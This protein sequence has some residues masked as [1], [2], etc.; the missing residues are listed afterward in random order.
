MERIFCI[1]G[2]A[3]TVFVE[4]SEL[5]D[6]SKIVRKL[7]NHGAKMCTRI[8]D[9]RFIIVD[10]ETFSG[11]LIVSEWGQVPDKIILAHS[12][13]SK[14]VDAKRLLDEMD[15]WGGCAAKG[16]T[17]TV[18]ERI[19]DPEQ[20]NLPPSRLRVF[21]HREDSC[22]PQATG[23]SRDQLESLRF[24]SCPSTHSVPSNAA[25]RSTFSAPPHLASLASLSS[26]LPTPSVPTPFSQMS[27]G[28]PSVIPMSHFPSADLSLPANGLPF[29]MP[30]L[31]FN[32]MI[33]QDPQAFLLAL[34]D[35]LR[36]YTQTNTMPAPTDYTRNSESY[37]ISEIKKSPTFDDIPIP[38][39][40]AN[41]TREQ[42]T[43][44]VSVYNHKDVNFAK[45]KAKPTT[46]TPVA[47]TSTS[48]GRF[49]FVEAGKP[50]RFFIQIDLRD[51]TK[52]LTTIKKL[53]GKITNKQDDADFSILSPRSNTYAS[54]L[55]SSLAVKTSA[56]GP[57]YV[58]DCAKESRLLDRTTYLLANE[59][60]AKKGKEAKVSVGGPG[61]IP[62]ERKRKASF[63]A[64]EKD[65]AK[66]VKKESLRPMVN[67]SFRPSPSPP[68][69]HARKRLDDGRYGYST[70]ELEYAVQYSEILLERNHEMPVSQIA[71]KLHEKMPHHP[72]KSWTTT[73]NQKN[74]YVR[75]K[76]A[77]AKKRA[78]IAYRKACAQAS[79]QNEGELEE[80]MHAIVYYFL[81][82]DDAD[83]A[84]G[85]VWAKLS[86]KTPCRTSRTW[87]DFYELHGQEI[88]RRYD[89]V[90]GQ[91]DR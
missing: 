82:D 36:F 38:E 69:E 80:D 61:E 9:A 67:L 7:K 56:V 79:S 58:E 4:A 25:E 62:P 28:P 6:R 21:K 13:V 70:E 49:I 65:R 22:T 10:P 33:T 26:R 64:D 72:V 17:T 42:A 14:C 63:N 11:R 87:Q 48:A 20:Q 55:R 30:M 90:K 66:K 77:D 68:P 86:S 45:G 75:D 5:V 19:E 88:H 76:I 81:Y 24:T 23:K 2:S 85:V 73:I 8:Q 27:G 41:M 60:K 39:E 74:Q 43:S 12:W 51:R 16:N 44:L 52:L 54:L 91:E 37:L 84:D 89:E 46:P 32:P 15:D 59:D 78:G 53:G 40:P 71:R 83:D 57:S 47:S 18:A 1:S 31:P 34:A 29:Q 35:Q 3:V 50:L